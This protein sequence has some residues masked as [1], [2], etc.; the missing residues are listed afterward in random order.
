[1]LYMWKNFG[2][3]EWGV[4]EVSTGDEI[5]ESGRGELDGVFW[6]TFDTEILLQACI[7]DTGTG[8]QS[9]DYL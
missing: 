5:G 6:D 2:E 4:G 3:H 8:S 9:R 1:M 7:D